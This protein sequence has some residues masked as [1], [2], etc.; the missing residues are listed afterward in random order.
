MNIDSF[1][2]RLEGIY[3]L[4]SLLPVMII[5]IINSFFFTT[6]FFR[7]YIQPVTQIIMT[8][9][10]VFLAAYCIIS[11]KIWQ[12]NRLLIGAM[13]IFSIINFLSFLITKE[14]S[15]F[16]ALS[17][18]FMIPVNY[19]AFGLPRIDI[20]EKQR[21]EEI[22]SVIYVF[23]IFA[24]VW[25]IFLLL[26]EGNTNG[27]VDILSGNRR[28][29]GISENPNRLGYFTSTAVFFSVYCFLISKKL[30]GKILICFA[31]VYNLFILYL[32]GNRSSQ[33]FL[34]IVLLGGLL[35]LAY[36]KLS[37]RR[38]LFTLL[39]MM[40]FFAI[41]CSFI[42]FSRGV[43]DGVSLYDL[44]N[45]ISS[46]RIDLY[47][48]GLK[49][50]I[51]SPIYGNSYSYLSEIYYPVQMAHNLY[52]DLFARYGIFSL[53]TFFVF[54]VAL[55][56]YS[57]CLIKKTSKYSFESADYLLFVFCFILIIGY[58]IQHLFDIFIF[59]SGY[60]AG[61]VFFII[62][63]GYLAYHISKADFKLNKR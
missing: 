58:L 36:K 27:L 21:R 9:Y 62:C 44:I 61:N 15:G 3:W 42:I 7:E 35:I 63:S 37:L 14:A 40:L 34:L 1:K 12:G 41:G 32:T 31:F 10:A 39:C 33:I 46:G 47:V 5:Y 38:F 26:I 29:S 57:I 16:Y 17:I 8:V 25:N 51:D 4:N 23:L 53:L 55:I 45:S 30:W 56:V 49:A 54:I 20:P 19:L 24:T 28:L 43:K 22:E 48:D 6:P 18:V 11:G 52:I 13:L 2:K 50:G 60:S 59:L